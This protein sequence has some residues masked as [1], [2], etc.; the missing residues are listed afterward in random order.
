M[1]FLTIFAFV[2]TLF[3]LAP[4]AT[5]ISIDKHLK[6]FITQ[7]ISLL[8]NLGTHTCELPHSIPPDGYICVSN[9]VR[10]WYNAEKGECEEINFNGCG[11]TA[12]NFKT[13]LNCKKVCEGY[14]RE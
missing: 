9:V 14:K 12:N 3:A 1:K 10:F 5:G 13:E 6:K 11:S 2:V 7:L 8:F 4:T